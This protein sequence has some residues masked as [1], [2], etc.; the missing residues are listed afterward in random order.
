MI[1]EQ[2]K[3]QYLKKLMFTALETYPNSEFLQDAQLDIFRPCNQDIV[4]KRLTAF[5]WAEQLQQEKK[6]L[7]FPCSWW[8]HL[9]SDYPLLQKF[10]G[11]PKMREVLVR[12]ERNAL[13]PRFVSL[14]E[15][16]HVFVIHEQIDIKGE[17]SN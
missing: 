16:K 17:E 8:D 3:K 10:F 13:Y 14:K 5:V 9:K 15:S 1:D 6:V 11:K 4:V 7:D 2:E 12:F